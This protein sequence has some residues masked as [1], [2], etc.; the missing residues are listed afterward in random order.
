V[1]ETLNSLICTVY[2]FIS[3]HVV[4]MVSTVT[5]AC[6][7]AM[8]SAY[9]S[10]ASLFDG[11][12]RKKAVE[13]VV[14]D[15]AQGF[16]IP[17]SGSSVM[18]WLR[19]VTTSVVKT[20]SIMEAFSFV[21]DKM[22]EMIDFACVKLYG[23]PFSSKGQDKVGIVENL[24]TIHAIL[25]EY[26]PNIS[27]S[28]EEDK[29]FAD[30]YRN[31]QDMQRKLL[32]NKDLGPPVTL[33]LSKYLTVYQ[34]VL[35]RLK[36]GKPRDTPLSVILA[37]PPG[38]G[39]ST[40]VR[41]I[42]KGLCKHAEEEFSDAS[43][44]HW[45]QENE[46]Q[47]TYDNQ[48]AI[49][50]DDI[51]QHKDPQM[52]AAQALSVI[53][54]V[55]TEPFPL[56]AAAIEKKGCLFVN[57]K[58][59]VST[60]NDFE[61]HNLAIQ[62]IH[63]LLRRFHIRIYTNSS[64]NEELLVDVECYQGMKDGRPTWG[65]YHNINM[66]ELSII[67]TR[68]YDFYRIPAVGDVPDLEALSRS[69]ISSKEF[70]PLG[71]WVLTEGNRRPINFTGR[72]EEESQVWRKKTTTTTTTTTSRKTPIT[73]RVDGV[74]NDPEV[75]DR[76]QGGDF[77][78]SVRVP[79]VAPKSE[80]ATVKE[81]LEK[82]NYRYILTVKK[83]FGDWYNATH[84][85]HTRIL[86]KMEEPFSGGALTESHIC[87]L[88]SHHG[89]VK[90][91]SSAIEIWY[92]WKKWSPVLQTKVDQNRPSCQ[93][94][95]AF[96]AASLYPDIFEIYDTKYNG[97]KEKVENLP[98]LLETKLSWGA[99]LL[100]GISTSD[101]IFGGA[102]KS[103][104][105]GY[106]GREILVQ[107]FTMACSLI[108]SFTKTEPEVPVDTAQS[109]DKF[110]SKV[111]K[112]R[113]KMVARQMGKQR[114]LA[115]MSLSQNAQDQ[116]VKF[117]AQNM[118]VTVNQDGM[119]FSGWIMFLK[120]GIG[121]LCA[122][123][124][125]FKDDVPVPG[126]IIVHM[127]K[128]KHEM[129]ITTLWNEKRLWF[130]KTKDRAWLLTTILHADDISKY[131]QSS[132]YE[133]DNASTGQVNATNSF[134]NNTTATIRI[135]NDHTYSKGDEL[136][137]CQNVLI[138]EGIP[139]AQ[140]DCGRMFYEK[141]ENKLVLLGYHVGG[142][143][144][145]S[146]VSVITREDW[147]EAH[148]KFHNLVSL[149][150]RVHLSGREEPDRAHFSPVASDFLTWPVSHTMPKGYNTPSES[151]FARSF[152]T[153]PE[154]G[155]PLFPEKMAP[156]LLRKKGEVHPVE[157]YSRNFVDKISK[158]SFPHLTN[159]E[160][161]EGVFPSRSK[162]LVYRQ[163]TFDEVVHTPHEVGLEPID[164]S[165]SPG[166]MWAINGVTRKQ[167]LNKDSIH[168]TQLKDRVNHIL[169]MLDEGIVPWEFHLLCPKDEPLP[170]H[171]V[172]AGNTRYFLIG[173]LEMH[174]VFKMFFGWFLV[175]QQLKRR[176]TDI[177]VGINPYS[178]D[179]KELFLKFEGLRCSDADIKK[180]DVNFARRIAYMFP[181]MAKRIWENVPSFKMQL[182]LIAILQCNV[183]IGRIVVIMFL[184]PSGTLITAFMNSVVNS[185]AHRIIAALL[186]ITLLLVVFGDDSIIGWKSLGQKEDDELLLNI[187]SLRK[188]LFGW[189]ST[190][191]TKV[192]DPVVQ[193]IQEC[194]F[195]KRSF[196][197]VG[198]T[199]LAPLERSSIESKMLSWIQAR[200][201]GEVRIKTVVNIK[202]ALMEASLHGRQY[203]EILKSIVSPRW[204][205][206]D[207]HSFLPYD[208][209]TCIS[210]TSEANSP[211]CFD[212]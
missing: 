186:A 200:T 28:V 108:S 130:D 6:V 178:L 69:A 111:Q 20:K 54:I 56:H 14:E 59:L 11:L 41:S 5:I 86:D 141:R 172:T 199:V 55:N 201:E 122:H 180:W 50:I 34:A 112:A 70:K 30:A 118:T 44:Y 61:F 107:L 143:S 47:D 120:G 204:K 156:A 210:K 66:K 77:P 39:K 149:D 169:Q 211:Q 146:V 202:V 115:Q 97:S 117:L 81:F 138:A 87:G 88:F 32:Y 91:F 49:V 139:G 23:V 147:D 198:N 102:I 114:D 145:R 105:V 171:K 93:E 150:V 165:T 25:E 9:P 140:G 60:T 27:H 175:Q 125:K 24:S 195:L 4:L 129:D 158:D 174:I 123:F 176:D 79:H 154:F 184:L 166:G 21:W 92:N 136:I 38:S 124:F 64:E 19:N 96:A 212:Y 106:V 48:F 58:V 73:T 16:S 40:M 161:W 191:A 185:V 31:L 68:A 194:Q 133:P 159:P 63:A 57:S 144:T 15:V 179:W 193:S 183:V 85:E 26:D 78:F 46:F 84:S 75:V 109:E 148:S 7:I 65:W 131:L 8:A 45:K 209:E 121:V 196:V 164:P 173:S 35:G 116:L 197:P 100:G 177:A 113:A 167:L 101:F 132:S 189:V 36:T 90:R 43:M 95:Y 182:L 74:E 192:G 188:S 2:D 18:A 62:D 1:S 17:V 207:V 99:R 153:D 205:E 126:R 168:Y 203:F 152:L 22:M 162:G 83:S 151:G 103:F 134:E 137:R 3:K 76:A 71:D 190:S 33:T 51:F 160:V 142:G 119:N 187:I 104:M 155:P 208:F 67:L 128:E 110:V 206:V 170:A 52:R 98:Q 94:M 89:D 181:C 127:G 157:V 53:S 72:S 42:V 12:F 29:A 80:L 13:V 82:Q 10:L 135:K 37:G 163:F